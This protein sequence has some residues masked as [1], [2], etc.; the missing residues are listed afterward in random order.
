M[1][2]IFYKQGNYMPI[3]KMNCE[4]CQKEYVGGIFP[5]RTT[6][7][8]SRTC[9][10][11]GFESS[12]IKYTCLRCNKDFEKKSFQTKGKFCS[13]KCIKFIGNKDTLKSR[14]NKG[15]WQLATEE[16]K[17]SLLKKNFD[18]IIVKKDGCWD[19]KKKCF[20]SGYFSINTGKR[21]SILAHRVSWM[22]YKGPIPDGLWVLHRCDNPRCTN[23]DHLFLGTPSDNM[24]D[25]IN[26]NRKN[27][28]FGSSHYNVLLNDDKVKDIRILIEQGYSQSNIGKKFNV[29]PSTIQNIADG[30]TWKHVK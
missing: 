12:L 8:C 5:S 23:P 24:R 13:I 18:R 15:P 19:T 1:H 30:K 17:L 2:V 20:D 29:S 11:K 25:C 21:K 22:I 9:M 4:I 26:K 14:L 3:L 10:A 28:P 16:E 27:P 6:K 7:F